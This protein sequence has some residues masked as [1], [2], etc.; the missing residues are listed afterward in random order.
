[1]ERQKTQNIQ[2]NT[3]EE[4]SW[5]TNTPCLR[6]TIIKKGGVGEKKDIDQLSRIETPEIDSHKYN[7]LIFDKGAKAVQ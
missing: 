6:F 7:E 5:R 2:H 1:M 4:Q 3:E